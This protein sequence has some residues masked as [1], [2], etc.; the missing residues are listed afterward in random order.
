MPALGII[1][2]F[3]LYQVRLSAERRAEHGFLILL[4]LDVLDYSVGLVNLIIVRA[5]LT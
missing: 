1:G 2:Y 3:V 4:G 5:W